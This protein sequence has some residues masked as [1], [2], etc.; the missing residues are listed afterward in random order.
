MPFRRSWS[1]WYRLTQA[2]GLGAA[3]LLV[4]S[5]FGPAQVASRLINLVFGRAC[6]R[7]GCRD[8]DGAFADRL[9]DPARHDPWIAGAVL[10]A[11]CFGLGSGLT[12]IVGGTLPLELFGRVGYGSR[13]G[14]CTSAKQLMSAIAPV[15]MAASMSEM[16]VVLSLWLVAAVGVISAL[17]FIGIQLTV[18]PRF[19]RSKMADNNA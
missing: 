9:G 16:G 11:I 18:E 2:L 7:H 14:W 1:T 3:G 19:A 4:A 5:L 15:A 17:A 13:I 6:P 12:S 10:F 8:R